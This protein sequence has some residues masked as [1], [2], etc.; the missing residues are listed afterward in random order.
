MQFKDSMSDSYEPKKLNIRQWMQTMHAMRYRLL[1]LWNSSLDH[2]PHGFV[3]RTTSAFDGELAKDLH[4][5]MKRVERVEWKV[6]YEWRKTRG[7][8]DPNGMIEHDEIEA[9]IWDKSFY[10]KPE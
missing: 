1:K 6:E 8:G 7:W 10:P 9:R 3:S 2:P 4:D 5:I